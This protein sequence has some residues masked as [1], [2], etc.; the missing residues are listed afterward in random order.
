MN[1][2][3]YAVIGV[4]LLIGIVYYYSQKNKKKDNPQQPRE[5]NPPKPTYQK[6]IPYILLLAIVIGGFW[7]YKNSQTDSSVS[8]PLSEAI[9]LS[10]SKTFSDLVVENKSGSSILKLTVADGIDKT[11]KDIQDKDTIIKSKGLVV[12]DVG[13]TPLKDLEDM[14]LV[15]PAKFRNDTA[16]SSINWFN[17]F[18]LAIILLL[19]GYLA[20]QFKG[21]TQKFTKD[22]NSI[23][24]KDVGGVSE[25]K[26]SLR[27][28]VDFLKDKDHFKKLGAKIPRGV[29]L[30][31]APG[32]GKTMLAR[33]IATEADVPFYYTTGSEFHTMWAGLAAQKV[34]RLFKQVKKTSGVIFIDEFDS[35]AHNRTMGT[36]DVGR[37]WNHT[38][39][40]LLAEMDGFDQTSKVVVL[41]AT[42]RA[43]VLDP[44][45][46]RPG[47]FDRKIFVPLP[48]LKD[49]VEILKVHSRG[50]PLDKVDFE[51]IAKQT[52]GFSGADLAL[53]MNE[54][55]I[56]AGREHKDR[57]S[58]EHIAKSI[59]KVLAG[60]ERKNLN[61]NEEQKKIVA[62]H[63]S[64]HAL[65]ASLIPEADKVQRISIIPRGQSGGFTRTASEKE[66]FV[67]S[68]SKALA[69]IKVLLGGRV[70]E[71]IK[72]NSKTSGAQLDLQRAN[73]IAREM[74]EHFGMGKSFGLRYANISS[75][76]VKDVS[77][78]AQ[79][80]VEN[81]MLGIF[82]E[83]YEQT[84]QLILGHTRLLDRLADELLKHESLN[85]SEVKEILG[86]V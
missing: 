50:K 27:E 24:F 83:C 74:V 54:A 47:R 40:Q 14:G 11:V 39:N 86:N 10:Q 66:Q 52:S 85:E 49:R 59:D 63:E 15:L 55:A 3:I 82:D 80:I 12:V 46:L 81:D 9:T 77:L 5:P 71:E 7:F 36:S 8:I 37:E 41:A 43:D 64:G 69:T 17:Y 30:E 23:S 78:D 32:V 62:Y 58:Q 72:L 6:Y 73:E 53:L 44:A 19:V 20:M 29:L 31:G 13:Y 1:S 28:V 38:L 51:S 48:S 60:D 26:D 45:V 79:K 16:Q 22:A 33:A 65:V 70:A 84:R 2:Q 21:N 18:N 35:V 4:L 56:I 57:I 67:I 25:V 42:N 76:G 61:L 68:E 75:Y 34:K